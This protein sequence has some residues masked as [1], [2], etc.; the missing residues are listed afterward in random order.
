M[1]DNLILYGTSLLVLVLILVLKLNKKIKLVNVLIFAF[2]TV[3][4]HIK[5]FYFSEPSAALGYW[6]YLIC[7]N[8]FH[9]ILLPL[10]LLIFKRSN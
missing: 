10:Q 8:V 1:E 4:M 9:S 3:Y 7:L 6:F 2:Y 5:W